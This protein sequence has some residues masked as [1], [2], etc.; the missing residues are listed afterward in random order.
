[1]GKPILVQEP[2]EFGKPIP[3]WVNITAHWLH[4]KGEDGYIWDRTSVERFQD[5]INRGP[6]C[7][8][9][10]L[11]LIDIEGDLNPRK[12]PVE[13]LKIY[14]MLRQQLPGKTVNAYAGFHWHYG[15]NNALE[16]RKYAL[17]PSVSD[18]LGKWERWRR[19][20][21]DGANLIDQSID[22]ICLNAYKPFQR[23]T[24]EDWEYAT[25]TILREMHKWYEGTRHYLILQPTNPQDQAPVT[26]DHWRRMIDFA[27]GHRYVD[28]VL[29]WRKPEW[30][31]APNW[32][33]IV[34]SAI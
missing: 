15:F 25:E 24:M 16:K 17:N 20:N 6:G 3:A 26:D 4:D 30:D 31:K 21:R 13:F 27:L 8:T 22:S 7:D 34:D 10:E 19:N 29:I 28:G 32:T 5:W 9:N 11:C 12:H 18:S 1:M 23:T 33:G 2:S 14:A